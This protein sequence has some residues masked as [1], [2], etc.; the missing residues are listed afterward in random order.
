VFI[1]TSSNNFCPAISQLPDLIRDE[2]LG[3]YIELT[4]E[5]LSHG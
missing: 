3:S 4:G 2:S 5:N 1:V